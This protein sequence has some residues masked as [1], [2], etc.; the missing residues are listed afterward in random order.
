MESIFKLLL[1][2][3]IAGGSI[4]LFAGTIN[5]IRK[6]GDRG[7]KLFGFFFQIGMLSAGSSAL[8]LSLIHP[9]YFLFVVG[10]FTLYLLGSGSQYILNYK[11]K[12]TKNKFGFA[13]SASMLI[14]GVGLTLTGGKLLFNENNFGLVMIAF[15]VIG[16]LMVRAD[17][18]QYKA[19]NFDG[20]KLLSL[21][22]QRMTAAYI[23]A[24][25]ALLVVNARHLPLQVPPVFIWL[26]PTVILTPLIIKWS[27]KHSKEKK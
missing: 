4:G 17:L 1:V 12:K 26:F 21:H 9:N 25:T 23:A 13:I 2:L 10:V 18:I 24:L 22:L 27:R 8:A 20:N 19:A 5:I 15:G 11:L 7:H 14:A 6:K 16:L 3:H